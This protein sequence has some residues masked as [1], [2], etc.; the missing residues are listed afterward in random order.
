VPFYTFKSNPDDIY[1]PTIWLEITTLLIPGFNDGP[2]EVKKLSEW[3]ITKL[4]PDV[5]LHFTAFHPDYKMT[6]LSPTPRG[7]LRMACDIAREAKV[8][9]ARAAASVSSAATGAKS[10]GGD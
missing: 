9:I 5:P 3:V 8:R 2:E 1:Q 10:P 6:N 4:G 7:T